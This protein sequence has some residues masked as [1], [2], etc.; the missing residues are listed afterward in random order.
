VQDENALP[1]EDFSVK[2]FD[3]QK[4]HKTEEWPRQ[5]F[6]TDLIASLHPLWSKTGHTDYQAFKDI[7]QLFALFFPPFPHEPSLVKRRYYHRYRR[8]A[9]T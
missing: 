4:R 6:W 9:A 7:A 2:P 1:V 8:P 3:P 5:E